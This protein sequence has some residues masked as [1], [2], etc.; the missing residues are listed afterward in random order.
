MLLVAPQGQAQG[1]INLV[2]NDGFVSSC[3]GARGK[4]RLDL[5]VPEPFKAGKTGDTA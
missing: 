2:D 5:T 1:E 3:I 4:F